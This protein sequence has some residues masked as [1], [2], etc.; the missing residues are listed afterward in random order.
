MFLKL[1]LL[2]SF[3]VDG[4]FISSIN[5]SLFASLTLIRLS[6][7]IIACS[8]ALSAPVRSTYKSR[9]LFV[10]AS[11]LSAIARKSSARYA[12]ASVYSGI[13][14]SCISSSAFGIAVRFPLGADNKSTVAIEAHIPSTVT[15]ISFPLSRSL[16]YIAH[17]SETEPPRQFSRKSIVLSSSETEARNSSISLKQV[18]STPVNRSFMFLLSSSAMSL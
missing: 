16:S 8:S 9:S 6:S 17:P 4:T 3:A 12:S 14:G 18:E 1:E 11:K 13:Y 15:A 7:S 2:L 5:P 10:S